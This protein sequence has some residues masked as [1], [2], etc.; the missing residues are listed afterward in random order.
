MCEL[1]VHPRLAHMMLVGEQSGLIKML[2][3][4]PRYYPIGIHWVETILIS[5]IDWRCWMSSQ[6]IDAIQHGFVAP[7][8]WRSNLNGV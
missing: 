2:L 4:W 7:W 1:P 6:A 8:I 3:V 5:M